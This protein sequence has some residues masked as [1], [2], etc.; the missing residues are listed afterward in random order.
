MIYDLRTYSFAPGNAQQYLKVYE[1]LAL[2]LQLKHQKNM[3]GF[4]QTDIG[5][6]NRTVSIWAYDSLA[7]REEAKAALGQEAQWKEYLRAAQPL[8][9]S[10]ENAIL[11]PAP[12][13]KK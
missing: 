4:W 7:A 12:F 1:E 5:P 2:A 6:L 11:K 8:I 10:Q 9:L 3:V 13:F